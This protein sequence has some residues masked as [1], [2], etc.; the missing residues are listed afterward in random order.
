MTL[1]TAEERDGTGAANAWTALRAEGR[2]T[3][4]A[5]EA[6]RTLADSPGRTGIARLDAVPAQRCG[7]SRRGSSRGARDNSSTTPAGEFGGG[8]ATV[9]SAPGR[10]LWGPPPVGLVIS[11]TALPRRSSDPHNACCRVNGPPRPPRSSDRA[12][13]VCARARFRSRG[14]SARKPSDHAGGVARSHEVRNVR[15]RLPEVVLNASSRGNSTRNVPLR[16]GVRSTAI[17]VECCDR[18]SSDRCGST[19][20]GCWRIASC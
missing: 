12:R 11:S 20:S 19:P 15:V 9:G 2:T 17:T 1:R 14:P 18:E 10:G 5:A 13:G 4:D 16:R 6:R 3:K 7:V 8:A